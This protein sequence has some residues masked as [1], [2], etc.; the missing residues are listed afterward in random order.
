MGVLLK[1]TK[2][3][4]Y[5]IGRAEDTDCKIVRVNFTDRNG[6]KHKNGYRVI[7]GTP[8]KKNEELKKLIEQLIEERGN[9]CDLNDIDVSFIEDMSLLFYESKFNGNISGWNVSRVTNMN[10]MFSWSDFNGDINDW[11]VSNVTNMNYI[12]L[13]SPLEDNPPKWY[14]K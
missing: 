3:Y 8:A 2:E 5:E 1:L 13:E 6:I 7:G 10:K 9:R 12:F 14:K 11:D 4:F